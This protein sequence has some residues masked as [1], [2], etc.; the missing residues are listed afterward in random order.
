MQNIPVELIPTFGFILLIIGWQFWFI[1]RAMNQLFSRAENFT[2]D[3]IHIGFGGGI[4]IDYSQRELAYSTGFSLRTFPASEIVFDHVWVNKISEAGNI[5]Q[6]N[7]KIIILTQ[8]YNQPEISMSFWFKKSAQK[9]WISLQRLSEAQNN[10]N[11]Q[12]Q[13]QP[14]IQV[15][16]SDLNNNPQST[17]RKL[18]APEQ[19]TVDKM[20]AFL[21]QNGFS[22][23]D[24]EHSVK[25]SRRRDAFELLA[26]SDFKT[27][28][29]ILRAKAVFHFLGHLDDDQENF[30]YKLNSLI[31]KASEDI[32]DF[33]KSEKNKKNNKL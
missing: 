22:R 16:P 11:Y 1:P 9:C 20:V 27:K 15:H 19:I 30:G 4:A 23:S 2:A 28:T 29:Q 8:E 31:T 26:E 32:N 24:G 7:H 5:S 17:P 25:D 12:Q 18:K 21:K 14:I 6:T 33:R 13:A 3:I 10:F